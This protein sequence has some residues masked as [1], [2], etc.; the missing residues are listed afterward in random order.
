MKLRTKYLSVALSL[1][2]GL[3]SVTSAA[4]P[5]YTQLIVLMKSGA[6]THHAQ[7]KTLKDTPP[8]SDIKKLAPGLTPVISPSQ[9]ST[10]AS[11]QALQRHR[12][13][14]YYV[15]D[16]SDKT[17]VQAEQLASQLR[18]NPSVEM[19]EFEPI[20]D[21]MQGDNGPPLAPGNDNDNDNDI[22]DYTGQQTYLQGQSPV[23]PYKIGGVN[24][25]RAWETQGGKGQN[26]RVI[27]SEIER[28]SYEHVDLPLP[29]IEL[30]SPTAPAPVGNHDTA[31]AGVI[32]SRENG[33]GTTGLVP[34]AQLGYLQWSVAR[35][36]EMAPTLRAGDVLQLG[37]HYK[38]ADDAFPSDVCTTNCYM[39]LEANQLVRDTIAYLTEEKGVHVVL[40]AANGNI[41]L[42]HPY[43]KS[44]YDRNIFDSGAI[45]AGAVNTKTGLRAYFSDYGSRVDLFSWGDSVTTTAW[46]RANPTTAYTHTFSG[47]SSANPIL[48]GAAASLQGVARANGLGNIP[49]KVLRSILVA[50][51]Y[52]QI[53]G[54]RTEIGVQPDLDAAIK[55]MLADHGGLPPTGRIAVPEEATSKEEFSVHV[56]AESPSNTPLNYRWS[57][58]G[59]MPATGTEATLQLQ[60]PT[61]EMDALMPISVEV[62]DGL[63]TLTLTDNIT[64][65]APPD[66]GGCADIAA[67]DPGKTYATYGES[68]AYANKVYKQNFYN[69][70]KRPDQN[71][72]D[73]GQPWFTGIACPSG[74]TSGY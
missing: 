15:I 48:A 11:L 42:D 28:W 39:P 7:D 67:W 73:H 40:A 64:I 4:T 59:F 3:P 47:T 63:H 49:P 58:P 68:V 41:N 55:K 8:L 5:G 22:P 57:A 38:Y 6:T 17:Q 74:S 34:Y 60:A 71:S 43:F 56:Y 53:N 18:T 9:V 66:N 20:V 44:W 2:A 12:L 27:S 72:A 24:A 23:A 19:A 13:D 35:L 37:V 31:S 51:G 16:T 46:N 65:K 33:F 61:V 14:R 50:T 54:N 26:I 25:V 1:V 62:S 29:F 70:N 45:F 30:H 32:A 21:G 52:P 36:G 10:T 69:L